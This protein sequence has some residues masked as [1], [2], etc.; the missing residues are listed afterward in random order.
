[1]R[2]SRLV[3]SP[4]EAPADR[5]AERALLGKRVQVLEDGSDAEVLVTT[6]NLRIDRPLLD[7]H[8]SARLVLTTTSGT[9]HLDL[10][11]LRDRG[12]AAARLPE[13]RRDA[14]VENSLALA[15]AGLHRLGTLRDRAVAGRWARAELPALG[16][17][18]LRGARVGIVGLGVIG[19]RMAEVAALLG[20]EVWGLDPAGLPPG[21]RPASLRALVGCDVLS[22]HCSLTDSS[23]D[24][25]DA[26][27]LGHARDLVL[28]NTARGRLLDVSAAVAA[29]DDGRLAFLGVDVFPEE[30]WPALADVGTRPDLVF[31]PHAA[32]FHRGLPQQVREG[33]DRAVCAWL[34]GDGLPYRVV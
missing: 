34:A 14:V 33:L 24:L 22:L 5:A 30:P 27:L 7:R 15:L 8:P 2:L 11:A 1:M 31:L 26:E 10:D 16:P 9:D 4:Y 19:R 23:R 20:A 12:I 32:G 25:V 13:A 21:V 18:N 28:I 3:W 6:S 17:R 29:L